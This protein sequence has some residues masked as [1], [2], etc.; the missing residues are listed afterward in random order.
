LNEVLTHN[1]TKQTVNTRKDKFNEELEKYFM[2]G[3]D[4][5]DKARVAC[6]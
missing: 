3:F 2:R 5:Q 4:P 6:S 1:F